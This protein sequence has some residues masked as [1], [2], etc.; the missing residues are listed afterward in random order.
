M[1]SEDPQSPG[2]LDPTGKRWHGTLQMLRGPGQY[3]YGVYAIA[4][5]YPQRRAVLLASK[6]MEMTVVDQ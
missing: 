5:L 2:Q 6:A 4:Y 1:V 3:R